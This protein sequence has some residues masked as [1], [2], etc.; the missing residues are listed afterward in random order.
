LVYHRYGPEFARRQWIEALSEFRA[1]SLPNAEEGEEMLAEIAEG[2]RQLIGVDVTKW[3]K[4]A[5]PFQVVTTGGLFQS[6]LVIIESRAGV[7]TTTGRH[8]C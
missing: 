5:A 1:R 6:Y 4:I 2:I 3:H 7:G 8:I